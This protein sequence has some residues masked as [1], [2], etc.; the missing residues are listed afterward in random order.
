MAPP[1]DMHYTMVARRASKRDSDVLGDR[2]KFDTQYAAQKP[3][4]DKNCVLLLD[5]G[6]IDTNMKL[7]LQAIEE[8]NFKIGES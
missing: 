7:V 5:S 2:K 8:R 4:W 1:P 6:D 3:A